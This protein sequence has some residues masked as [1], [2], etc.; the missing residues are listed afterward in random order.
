MYSTN[1]LVLF[2]R[3]LRLRC[4][5]CGKGKIFSGFFKTYERCP[6]CH[7]RYEREEGYYTGAVAINLILT[8]F[9]LAAVALPVAASQAVSLPVMIALGVTLPILLPLLFYRL[10]KS[11]WMS[12]DHFIHPVPAEERV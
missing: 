9:V 4:P 7:F 3:G 10:T 1:F 8:E 11:L 6:N 5:V 2:L 12:L